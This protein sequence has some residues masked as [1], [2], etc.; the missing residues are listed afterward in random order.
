MLGLNSMARCDVGVKDD[1]QVVKETIRIEAIAQ[2]FSPTLAVSVATV[3]SGLNPRALGRH[4][5]IGL[6]QIMPYQI[7]KQDDHDIQGNTRRGI[8]ILQYWRLHCPIREGL[9]YLVCYNG[10][11]RHPK[12]PLLHPYYLHVMEQMR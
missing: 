2:N 5:E 3:E 6:F 10:G 12:Y 9:E 1:T 4:G 11:Y 8:E 7:R